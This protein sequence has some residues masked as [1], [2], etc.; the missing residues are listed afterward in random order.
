MA[1]IMQAT[2]PTPTP[3]PVTV[4]PTPVSVA[5]GQNLLRDGS[6]EGPLY[7]PCTKAG[8]WPWNHLSCEGL[9]LRKVDGK[10]QYIRWDTVQVPIG[11]KAGLVPNS[12]HRDPNL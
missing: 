6:F 4:E 10:R 9:D 1:A 11:W 8:D 2:Y 3:A 12:N 5:L 7:I